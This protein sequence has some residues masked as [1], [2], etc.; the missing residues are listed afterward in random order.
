MA[1]LATL[2]VDDEPGARRILREEL[3]QF[4][5][6][7]IVG[8]AGD[9]IS[10]VT[11]IENLHP[12]LVFLDLQ[13]PGTGGFEV[14]RKLD[15][16]R[17]FPTI[18]I[19]T[20]RDQRA[21]RALDAGAI[22]YLLKPIRHER[23]AQT[24]GRVQRVRAQPLAAAVEFENIR[25]IAA[26]AS[27]IEAERKVVARSGDEYVFLSCDD[28]LA[29]EADGEI[30]WIVTARK[31][32]T[33]TATLRAIQEKFQNSGFRRVHRNALVNIEHISRMSR[34]TSQRWLITLTN[35]EE[36]VVSKRHART[37][38]DLLFR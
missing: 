29:F 16:V 25:K 6:V 23:L 11:A 28:V 35:N 27:R 33:A 14:I 3:E 13:M 21:I 12:D 17:H 9:S 32:Y 37:L 4:E 2:I 36:F 31:R 15:S 8:E 7:A 38:K 20:A 22:D 1:R 34:L 30:V 24:L 26:S 5:E 10:A 19:V 18:A